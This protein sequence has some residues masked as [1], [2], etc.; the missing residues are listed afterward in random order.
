MI[1]DLKRFLFEAPST[2]DQV[3]GS[4]TLKRFILRGTNDAISCVL[5]KGLIYI[6]GTDIDRSL[7]FRFHAF[8]R[9]VTN[10]KKFEEGIFSDLHNLK[11]ETDSCLE[12]PKSD[13]LDFF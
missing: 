10:V 5:W 7:I 9:L 8:G 6:T 4:M 3:D 13:F 2:W 11:L 12:C 1:E